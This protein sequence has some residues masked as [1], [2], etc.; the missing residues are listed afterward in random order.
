VA[1][2]DNVENYQFV[3]VQK[4]VTSDNIFLHFLQN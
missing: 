1:Q 2:Q 3:K 4:F